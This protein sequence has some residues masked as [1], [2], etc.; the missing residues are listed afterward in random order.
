[1]INL[2]S[3]FTG[4]RKKS[5]AAAQP[6]AAPTIPLPVVPRRA[7]TSLE[8]RQQLLAHHVRLVARGMANGLC[9]YGS[10]GGLGKTRVVLATLKEEGVEPVV[11]TGHCTPLAMYMSLYEH[12]QSVVFL[13]D[14]DAMFRILPAL[15]ILRSAL[16]EGEK[17]S[18]L[19]NYNSSQ[20]KVPSSFRFEG[21]IV[22]AV[23]T[24]PRQ[25]FAF[26]AVLSRVDQFELSA[27]NEE[28]LEMMRRL[29]AQGF[30]GKLT[31]DEC[32]EVVDF[33]SEFSAT[34]ELSLRLLEPSLKK[35]LYAREEGVDW[36]Q[37]VA[38]Q[39]HEIGRTAVPKIPEA[40]AYDL[41]CLKQVAADYPDSISE[42]EAAF[43]TLTRRSRAT[44]FRLKRMLGTVSEQVG[45]AQA[46]MGTIG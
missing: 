13:D 20:L 42:Q 28:V 34:R 4:S 46:A 38:S 23:N 32:Q 39:L 11:L 25:N 41:E 36:R 19:V 18:R 10:R 45:T 31:A 5:G 14:C 3:L 7:P 21:R 8:E 29:A 40:R 12:P 2:L 37:L 16:W 6:P 30:E 44:F 43:R 27:S 24:L 26:N 22:F 33:V 35:V 9:V 17:G 15:G 1:M